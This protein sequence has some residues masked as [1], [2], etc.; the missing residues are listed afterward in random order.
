MVGAVIGQPDRFGFSPLGENLRPLP[1]AGDEQPDINIAYGVSPTPQGTLTEEM[2]VSPV[3]MVKPVSGQAE[4]LVNEGLSELA[5]FEEETLAPFRRLRRQAVEACIAKNYNVLAGI[6]V[7]H[8]SDGVP[9]TLGFY[10]EPLE[11]M[12]FDMRAEVVGLDQEGPEGEDD[13]SATPDEEANTEGPINSFSFITDAARQ[14]IVNPGEPVRKH[15]ALTLASLLLPAA[16]RGP[17]APYR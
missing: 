4:G 8:Y 14:A 3:A 1:T 6:L 12:I 15:T 9:Y 13:E 17:I 10:A 2:W 16:V 11:D 5:A 7:F